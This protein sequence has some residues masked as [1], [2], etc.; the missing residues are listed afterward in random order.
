MDYGV[1]LPVID[2]GFERFSL[3]RLSAY[4]RRAEELRF[5]A[6]STNDHLIYSRLWLDAPT[7][8][9]AVLAHTGKMALGTS[10][11]LPV[12]RACLSMKGR[13]ENREKVGE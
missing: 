1:H 11:A 10:V 4:V 6:V 7:A 13:I 5:E 8:L 12:V 3:E 2:F 9:A